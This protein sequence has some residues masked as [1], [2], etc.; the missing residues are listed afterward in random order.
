MGCRES[1]GPRSISTWISSGAGLAWIDRSTPVG[2]RSDATA[3]SRGVASWHCVKTSVRVHA[4]DRM[5]SMMPPGPLSAS[6]GDPHAT[7]TKTKAVA[8]TRWA[9]APFVQ[10]GR[11][12]TDLLRKTHELCDGSTRPGLTRRNRR[13]CLEPSGLDTESTKRRNRAVPV[14]DLPEEQNRL[15]ADHVGRVILID[16]GSPWSRTAGL[17]DHDGAPHRDHGRGG[18]HDT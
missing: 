7:A 12:M 5:P 14:G 6:V 3:G 15:L 16:Q 8:H 11:L 9:T 17:L 10:V 13:D 18:A 2:P 4:L 1:H